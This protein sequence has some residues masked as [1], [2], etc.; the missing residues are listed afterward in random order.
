[1]INRE[2]VRAL[3]LKILTHD[4]CYDFYVRLSAEMGS[5]DAIREAVSWWKEDSTKLNHL[6]WVLNYYSEQFDPDRLLRAHIER[7][8][9]AIAQRQATFEA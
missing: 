4:M 9:D 5:Q 7:H 1:M 8:L 2:T 6:W 3:N